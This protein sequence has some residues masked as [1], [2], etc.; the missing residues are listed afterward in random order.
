M[1][2]SGQLP[3]VWSILKSGPIRVARISPIR[4][5]EEWSVHAAV[6]IPTIDMTVVLVISPTSINKTADAD[7]AAFI[8]TGEQQTG[9]PEQESS[10]HPHAPSWAIGVFRCLTSG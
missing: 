5:I 1:V 6:D 2:T 10:N 4:E 9:G 8:T 3:S 7:S